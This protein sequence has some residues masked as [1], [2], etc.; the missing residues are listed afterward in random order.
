MRRMLARLFAQGSLRASEESSE[1]GWIELMLP[2]RFGCSKTT[3]R[4]IPSVF[5]PLGPRVVGGRGVRIGRFQKAQQNTTP[6]PPTL[7]HKFVFYGM[8]F[9]GMQTRIGLWLADRSHPT[10]LQESLASL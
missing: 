4:R 3:E 8:G 6:S 9:R 2:C 5:A 7:T 10:K 1:V